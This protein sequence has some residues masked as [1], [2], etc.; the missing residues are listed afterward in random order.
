MFLDSF[1]NDI[2]HTRVGDSILFEHILTQCQIVSEV[3]SI[4]TNMLNLQE[5]AQCFVV[6][7]FLKTITDYSTDL[8]GTATFL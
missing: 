1:S 5:L 7:P 3:R 2:P 4:A 6:A 8:P